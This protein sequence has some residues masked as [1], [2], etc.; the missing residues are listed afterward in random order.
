M[1]TSLDELSFDSVMSSYCDV[2]VSSKVVDVEDPSASSLHA[3]KCTIA[4]TVSNS[5]MKIISIDRPHDL[6]Q[7]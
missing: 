2:L 4:A 1:D 3:T 6:L 5:L 7:R